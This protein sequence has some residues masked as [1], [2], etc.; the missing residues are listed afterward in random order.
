MCLYPNKLFGKS[1]RV[2]FKDM[3]FFVTKIHKGSID[4]LELYGGL[5]VRN[6][7]KSCRFVLTDKR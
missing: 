7:E 5:G 2:F 3:T 1:S 6:C 4:R